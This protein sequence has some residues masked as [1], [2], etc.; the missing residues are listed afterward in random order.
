[1]PTILRRDG[2][3]LYFFG[4]EPNEP[5]HVHVDRAGATAKVWRQPVARAR[6]I[7]F[8]PAELRGLL[9]LVAEHRT[10]LLEAWNGYFGRCS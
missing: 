10:E 4:H 1:M 5:P 3:R 7:G 8:A 2:F 9:R 6:N